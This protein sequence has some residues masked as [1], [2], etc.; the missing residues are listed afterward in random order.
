[1]NSEM[2]EKVATGQGFIAALD[3]SGGST[4][5]ALAQYGVAET[6]YSGETAMFDKVH[7]M[8]TR[9]V[10]SPSFTGERILGAILFEGTMD[11]QIEGQPTAAYLWNVKNVVPFLKVDKGLAEESDGAQL[12]KPMPEL[13]A[14]LQR[15]VANAVF[16]T[17]MRSVI[18]HGNAA[19]VAAIVD[20]QFDV[21]EQILG[22]GL[23]PIIEPEVDIHAPDK[24]AAEVLLKEQLK[25]RL[26]AL[27]D[28]Q[29]VMLKLTI[30]DVDGFYSDLIADPKV[31]RVVALSGGYS[32]DDA[33][34]KLARNP[35]LIA[36]FSRAL[37]EG[38]S[39]Q[40]SDAE[41]NATLGASIDAIYAA[42]IA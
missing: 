30:P 26:A 28:G 36:S 23:V 6:E 10:T 8:R 16:G 9:I 32:R 42:S 20:Q 1:M 7:E 31:L 41:F 18:K 34:A 14:L 13:D 27:P 29:Q 33:N 40:Q 35:G 15:A 11:R 17:K 3:Q 5:K 25:R 38:L 4:P 22:H 19:G 12:M 21:G 37:V 24:A 2:R 39:A